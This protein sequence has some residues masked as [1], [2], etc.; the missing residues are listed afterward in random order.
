MCIRDRVVTISFDATGTALVGAA[1]VY[2]HAGVS[3]TSD[4]PMNFDKVI[5]NWGQ[6]DGIGEMTNTGTDTWEITLSSLS[7]YFGMTATEDI[8]GLNF[9][10]RNADGTSLEDDGGNNYFNDVETGNHFVINSPDISPALILEN[11]VQVID[12][13]AN[14]SADWILQE[15]D[16]NENVLATL[17]QTNGVANFNF[18]YT[19]PDA[20]LHYF[21]LIAVI[22]GETRYQLFQIKGYGQVVEASRPSG[23]QLGINYHPNDATKATL[24][25]HAPTYTRFFKGLG[26]QTGTNNTIAKE[27]VYV[28][29]DFNN[30][31]IQE[32]F[33]MKRDRDGWDGTTDADNDGDRGDYWWI[34]LN[35]L[36]PGQEYVFQ[37]LIDGNLQ[38]A[39]P[40]TAQVSDF[41]D[42]HIP[43][44]VYPN[45]IAYPSEAI[46][47]ASVLQTDQP[48][49][50]WEVLNFTA[51]NKEDLN[52]Y[53]LHFR[54]FTEDGTYLAAIDKLDYIKNTG[55]NAIHVM[56]ISEFEG[57][58]SW[59]YNPNFYFA[60]DK[61]YGTEEDLKKFVDEAHKRG[62]A[63][64][65]DVVLNHTFFSNVMARM[66]W[67]DV[68]NKPAN[69]NPWLNP[70][71]KMVRNMAGWWGADWNHESE[72]TQNM[73]NR[74][75]IPIIIYP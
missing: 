8:F 50:D 30:W 34:E 56:P 46:D 12:A 64:F 1:K 5:G 18:S 57:N 44:N 13:V 7:T 21:K 58:S 39:D 33:Q 41:D 61:A 36:V 73:V 14:L 67:N 9:L 47:R 24:I 45:L 66:Y 40:Y 15:V 23:M 68:D 10:F 42:V 20:N 19:V 53:E 59:G 4:S 38:V 32:A 6:D 51:A 27:F 17:N 75:F 25:L 2:L 55:I 54:D 71:H 70:D 60:P 31:E 37:Y 52:I 65:N 49:Y 69:D 26:T 62:I 28:I 11:T 22:N 16:V 29:G 74:I 63:V 3:T 35:N 43:S 72:H 48:T